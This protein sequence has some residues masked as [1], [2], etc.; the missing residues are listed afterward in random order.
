MKCGASRSSTT[1]R[2]TARTL[3]RPDQN[4]E[5]EKMR[6]LLASDPE[7]HDGTIHAFAG[8]QGLNRRFAYAAKGR[9]GTKWLS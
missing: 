3:I 8:Q 4:K 9:S 2:A 6:A 5:Y 7:W 1:R